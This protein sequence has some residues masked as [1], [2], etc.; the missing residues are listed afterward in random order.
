MSA[1]K[2]N[3]KNEVEKIADPSL[4]R[5]GIGGLQYLSHTRPDITFAMNKVS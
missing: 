3:S 2:C 4:Y 1:S 5:S